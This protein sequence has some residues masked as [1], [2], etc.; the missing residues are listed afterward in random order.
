[1]HPIVDI[2]RFM[3]QYQKENN[4]TAKCLTNVLYIN[5][6]ARQYGLKPKVKAVAVIS[7]DDNGAYM[8]CPKHVVIEIVDDCL[9]DPSYEMHSMSK[10][11][12]FDTITELLQ[13]M[14]ILKNN[15]ETLKDSINGFM[16]F[17]K[18]ANKINTYCGKGQLAA[19]DDNDD[20]YYNN[21]ADYVE[22]MMLKNGYK[23]VSVS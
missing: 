7:R 8:V 10:K 6:M 23:M 19:G 20:S 17:T 3:H 15:K 4:I 9:I 22:S 16:E 18:N 21:Q 2:L 13:C 1:M 11:T 5:N 14:P 12:Y